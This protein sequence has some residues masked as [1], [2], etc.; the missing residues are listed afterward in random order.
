[1]LTKNF[2]NVIESLFGRSDLKGTDQSGN[3]ISVYPK[4]D[5]VQVSQGSTLGTWA[6]GMY[7]PGI[8][9]GT[10]TTEPLPTDYNLSGNRLLSNLGVTINK[11]KTYNDDGC[12]HSSVITVTN[13]NS[14]DITI[15]EVA[16]FGYI[17]QSNTSS[18]SVAMFD[19]TLLDEPLT[20]PAG[21]TGQITYTID[22]NYK[23]Q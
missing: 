12:K 4:A 23:F 9:L 13:N 3:T 10:G 6:T 14:S 7:N 2:Y 15:T 5:H 19:R 21:G 17:Y 22:F 8:G 20:I 16:W 11:N 1:M 18:F